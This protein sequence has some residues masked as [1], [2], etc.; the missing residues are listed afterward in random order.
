MVNFLLLSEARAR[1]FGI[2][3]NVVRRAGLGLEGGQV[4]TKRRLREILAGEDRMRILVGQLST[5]GREVRS[6]TMQWAYEG[7][8]LDSTVKHM[9]WVPPWVDAGQDEDGQVPVGRRFLGK[10]SKAVPDEVGLGRHPSLWWTLNC[11]YNDAYDVQ[12]MNTACAGGD[13]ALDEQCE[14]DKQERFRFTRDSPDLVAYMLA[15]RT[16]LHMRMVMPAIVPHNDLERYMAMARFETGP[17]GNP[18]WHGFSMGAAGPKVER[19]EAD[20]EG[21]GDVPPQTLPLDVRAVLKAF[22]KESSL[23]AWDYNVVKTRHEV[24]QVVRDVLA[25]EVGDD[26]EDLV[27]GRSSGSGSDESGVHGETAA[28]DFLGGRVAAVVHALVEQ[29]EVEELTGE[30]AE[31][32][33]DVKYRRVPP[34]PEAVA[35][36]R[37]GKGRPKG[38]HD[39]VQEERMTAPLADLGIMKPEN[40]EKQ[41]QSSLEQQ[42]AA[43]FKHV[44]S[45][46]N[47]CKS[48]DGQWRYTWD[49]EIGAHDVEVELVDDGKSN[50]K[51]PSEQRAVQEVSGRAPERVNLRGLLDNVFRAENEAQADLD[52]QRVRRLVAALVNRV[53]RHTKHGVHAPR[54]GVHACARGKESCPVCRYGFPRTL[55]ARGGPRPMIMERGE[56]EG[57]WHARFPRNDRLCCSYEA[58]VLLANMGN[59]DWRP[60]LNLWAVV[61]YVTKYAT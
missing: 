20:V 46:W 36:Q 7:K 22:R 51:V 32:Q 12:R 35:A 57:Q 13:A 30:R 29:G 26:E 3:R 28:V 37:K 34:V 18:H 50:G 47:P 31:E 33:G 21:L 42:F 38:V 56:R 43:F 2:Y 9:S 17:G 24:C 55:V 61:Q 53:A 48:D 49:E 10:E 11:K 23:A 27:E 4:L 16:E 19:V 39:G 25:G 41:L 54:I 59:V 44:V 5:V 8:K 58:H 45:E 6:T 14:G 52:V 15:L 1:G 60:V 40:E